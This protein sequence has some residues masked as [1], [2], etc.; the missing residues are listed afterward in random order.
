MIQPRPL[1]RLSNTAGQK[2]KVPAKAAKASAPRRRKAPR[3]PVTHGATVK[4]QFILPGQVIDTVAAGRGDVTLRWVQT[5]WKEWRLREIKP[6]GGHQ[7]LF[8][9]RIWENHVSTRPVAWKRDTRR[10]D[11]LVD[12]VRDAHIW[13]E[14]C[15]P[16]DVPVLDLL[17][18]F[19][20][21]PPPAVNFPADMDGLLA[22][23]LVI[24][25]RA[26]NP[27][28]PALV[29]AVNAKTGPARAQRLKALQDLIVAG[30]KILDQR[31]LGDPPLTPAQDAS[32]AGVRIRQ[33]ALWLD[34]LVHVTPYDKAGFEARAGVIIREIIDVAKVRLQLARLA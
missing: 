30:R 22:D 5:H 2:P 4:G 11:L 16:I 26:A 1:H 34:V 29:H 14:A 7:D 27:F 19:M 20:K 32:P 33:L 18:K 8:V 13:A 9:L 6:T 3:L 23:W 25:R 31:R 28:G 12:A 21:A 17:L 10:Y 15:P 24:L